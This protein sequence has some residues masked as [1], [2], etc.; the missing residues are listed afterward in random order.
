M[1]HIPDFF[2]ISAAKAGTTFL[3]GLDQHPEDLH[4][5]AEGA[6]VFTTYWNQGWDQY[7]QCFTPETGKRVWGDASTQYSISGVYPQAVERLAKYAPQ[8]KLIYVV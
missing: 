1:Q 6:E 8:A 7:E 4:Q 3:A 2:L 5:P